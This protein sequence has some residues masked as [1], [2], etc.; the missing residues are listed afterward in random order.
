MNLT[1]ADAFVNGLTMA[2]GDYKTDEMGIKDSAVNYSLYLLF[3]GL[4]VLEKLY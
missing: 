3:I 1:T 2:L 4:I